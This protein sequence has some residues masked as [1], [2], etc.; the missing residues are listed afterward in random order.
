ML[1][2]PVPPLSFGSEPRLAYVSHQEFDGAIAA[3]VFADRRIELIGGLLYEMPPMGDA[4]AAATRYLAD[5]FIKTLPAGRVLS[6]TPIILPHDGQPEPDVAVAKP[7]ATARPGSAEV[8]LVIE[9]SASTRA[10]DQGIKLLAY[11][12]DG[13]PEV[14][15]VD[16][17]D[18]VVLVY[19]SQALFGRF[20]RDTGVQLSAERVPEVTLDVDALFRAAR[21]QP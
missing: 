11:L 17:I 14:W 2:T 7:G 4:H 3:G 19:R 18:Q 1:L 5:V 15:I 13:I 16:L 20:A 6:Q 10:F 21:L 9:V 8:Q 12:A